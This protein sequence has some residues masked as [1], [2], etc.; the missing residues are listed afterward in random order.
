MRNG[1]SEHD[2]D[3]H[4]DWM[5]PFTSGRPRVSEVCQA[6][7]LTDPSFGGCISC[8]FGSICIEDTAKMGKVLGC[9]VLSGVHRVLFRWAEA[10]LRARWRQLR[11]LENK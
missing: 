4:G 3:H 7:E 11:Q 5:V 10:A 6:P 2:V 9:W 1:N 8:I